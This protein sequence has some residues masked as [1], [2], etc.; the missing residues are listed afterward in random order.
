MFHRI[1]SDG[2][3]GCLLLNSLFLN[4]VPQACPGVKLMFGLNWL[5]FP[6]ND[7]CTGCYTAGYTSYA[8][9]TG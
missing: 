3:R 9:G 1:A 6:S 4:W 2:V 5:G 8:K 7:G